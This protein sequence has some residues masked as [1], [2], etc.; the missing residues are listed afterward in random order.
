MGGGGA[1]FEENQC[2]ISSELF[3]CAARG[4]ENKKDLE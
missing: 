2:L 3:A 1:V 4:A